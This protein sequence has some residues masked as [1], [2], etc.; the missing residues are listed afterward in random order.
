MLDYNPTEKC[1]AG[2]RYEAEVPDTLDLSD[3]MDLAINALTNVWNP[4]EKWSLAF[5]VDFSRR[6]AI[7]YTNHLTDAYLN[8]PPKFLEALV[9]CRLASGSR[10]NLDVDTG[11]LGAQLDFLG[12]DGLT[13]CPTGTLQKFTEWRTFSEVWAEGRLL[14][15]L[16][17]LAQVDDNPRWVEIGKRKVDRLLALTREKDGFRF[18]WKGRFRPGETVPADA[19]E[20]EGNLQD[21]SL[22]DRYVDPRMSIIYS[23]G[24]LGHG[25][26]LFFRVTG[27][28]PALELS[29]G[30]AH[31]ALARIFTNEDGRWDI[32]H[33]HHSLYALMAVSVDVGVSRA[34]PAQEFGG[35][36]G[37]IISCERLVHEDVR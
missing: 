9:V 10:L 15:A 29:R 1:T 27:Y 17:M 21:G 23:V 18:L 12:D 8:I 32:Y 4:D 25:S 16:S 19:G 24:A 22:L 11:V 13:Y 30:L 37:E 26:G 2:Q 28:E 35:R 3:R 5:D 31:W 6:P 36:G 7:L 14:L 34:A 33:F 20:P